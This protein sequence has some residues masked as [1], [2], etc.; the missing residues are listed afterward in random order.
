MNDRLPLGALNS[1][2]R[3]PSLVLA[4][5]SLATAW[6]E[7]TQPVSL[8]TKTTHIIYSVPGTPTKLIIRVYDQ[9]LPQQ[10][11]AAILLRVMNYAARR[12]EEKGDVALLKREDPFWIDSKQGT[13]FGIWSLRGATLKYS[14]LESTARGIWSTMYLEGKYQPASIAIYNKDR[15]SA[16]RG[17]AVI[18]E[19]TL[20]ALASDA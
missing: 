5:T 17:Y 4:N 16:V 15:G 13:V 11:M 14:E 7:T 12:I 2:Q 19:G 10:A 18:R 20:Q 8:A 1:L 3:V 6:L 9:E